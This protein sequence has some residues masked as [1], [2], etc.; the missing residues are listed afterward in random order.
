MNM[1]S[2]LPFQLLPSATGKKY[3]SISKI[4]HYNPAIALEDFIFAYYKYDF[5]VH[6]SKIY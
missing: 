2:F 4:G 5:Q 1:F 3:P 6:H